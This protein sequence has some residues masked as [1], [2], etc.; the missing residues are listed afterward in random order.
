MKYI[1][2]KKNLIPYTFNIV[3][4]EEVYDMRIDYN[5]RAD[6]FTV[7]LSKDGNA[8][9]IGEPIIYGK[10]LFADLINRGGF[11]KVKI[12]PLDYSGESTAVTYD[13]LGRTVFLVVTE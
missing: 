9:C 8:L 2:V 5:N 1:D 4:G 12:T 13:N 7:S 11:P 6:L 10:P 3:L